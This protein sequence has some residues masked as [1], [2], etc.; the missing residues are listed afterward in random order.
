MEILAG[1]LV[2]VSRYFLIPAEAKS[3]R[4]S[5]IRLQLRFP[6]KCHQKRLFL[7]PENLVFELNRKGASLSVSDWTMKFVNGQLAG[8]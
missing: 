4:K 7:W 8:C 6:G 2:C 5:A 3:S 1:G